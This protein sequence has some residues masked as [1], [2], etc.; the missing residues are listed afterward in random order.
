MTD[1]K[2]ATEDFLYEQ[3]RTERLSANPANASTG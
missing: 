3:Y 1:L 2:D